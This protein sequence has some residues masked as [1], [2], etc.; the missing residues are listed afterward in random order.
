MFDSD[1]AF[2]VPETF[3][4]DNRY[5]LYHGVVVA[6]SWWFANSVLGWKMAL[7]EAYGERYREFLVSTAYMTHLRV[8]LA[9]D[10]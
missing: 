10:H 7:G 3:L 5:R 6:A 4:F 2:L 1:V 9:I 8:P